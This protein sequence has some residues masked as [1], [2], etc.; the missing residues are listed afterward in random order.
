MWIFTRSETV[1]KEDEHKDEEKNYNRNEIKK[2]NENKNKDENEKKEENALHYL[3]GILNTLFNL[4]SPKDPTIDL[5]RDLQ[6]CFAVYR[7]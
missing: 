1:V 4:S 5:K 3:I 6:L 2:E 7:F